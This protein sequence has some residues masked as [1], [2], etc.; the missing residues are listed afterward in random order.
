MLRTRLALGLAALA[1]VPAAAGALELVV[2]APA[3]VNF[4]SS[5]EIKIRVFGAPELGDFATPSLRAF[6]VDV[7][8]DPLLF[9]FSEASCGEDLGSGSQTLVSALDAA[10]ALDLRGVSLLPVDSLESQQPRDFVLAR[11]SFQAL[12][13][14]KATFELTPTD[15]ADLVG[16][17]FDAAG[18]STA[19][20]EVVPE[21]GSPLLAAAGVVALA[22]CAW[23]RRRTRMQPEC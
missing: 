9:A 17:S 18:S 6:D 4:G 8:Y 16:A 12:A 19:R 5:F 7:L 11:L 1:I 15:V 10:G 2:R 3:T 21:P 13:A 20:V 14:G 22:L 23:R